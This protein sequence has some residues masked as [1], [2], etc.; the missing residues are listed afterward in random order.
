MARCKK[1]PEAVE[2]EATAQSIETPPETH[3]YFSEISRFRRDSYGL[4]ENVE[5]HFNPDGSINWREMIPKEY[6]VPNRDF[7]KG[8]NIDLKDIDISKLPDNQLLILLGGIKD[9]AQIRGFDN[10]EYQVI[11]AGSEYVAVKCTI[12]WTPNFE[13]SFNKISFSALADAHLDNTKDFAKNFLMAIAENRAFIRCVRNFLKINIVGNEEIGKTAAV[14]PVESPAPEDSGHM[15][16]PISLLKSTMSEYGVAF[17]QIK[18]RAIQKGMDGAESWSC[19]E[20][21]SPLA[22]FT[23]ISGIKNKNKK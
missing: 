20:D 12:D 17:A 18:D 5:Y 14:T 16:K 21:I 19:I 2:N 7:F 1:N 11:S 8:K 13:T 10:V 9:L 3:R 6:L 4:I 23:I 15:S 22:M